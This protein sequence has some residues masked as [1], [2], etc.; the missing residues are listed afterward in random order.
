MEPTAGVTA[1]FA[2]SNRYVAPDGREICREWTGYY[3][4]PNKDGYLILIDARFFGDQPFSFGVKEEMGLGVRVATPLVVKGGAGSI[5]AA[6]GGKNESGTWGKVDQWWN[7]FGTL[8]GR[9]AGIQIMSGPG[10]PAVWSHSR[11]YGVLVANPFPVDR[12]PNRGKKV[13]VKPGEKFRLKFGI[14]VHEHATRAA[15]DPA[16]S[17]QR[18]LKA[19]K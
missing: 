8:D 1:S 17:Y 19:A 6:S 14:Q 13:T 4:V 5:L 18:Y 7:Y 16:A 10:N 2:T 15:F 12:P 3:L 9:S 11:D